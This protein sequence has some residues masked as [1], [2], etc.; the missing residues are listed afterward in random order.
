MRGLGVPDP[1]G[2]HGRGDQI[3]RI[4]VE[5]PRKLGKRETELVRELESLQEA[6]P[7]DARK[8]FLDSLKDWIQGK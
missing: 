3:V 2:R 5:V 1:H 7:G 8:S 6:H 4:L